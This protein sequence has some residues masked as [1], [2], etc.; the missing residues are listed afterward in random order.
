MFD[1]NLITT[2]KNLLAF[3][4]GIDSSA[5]F[6][7]LLEKNIQFD[8]A[9]VNYNIR[10]QSKQEVQYAK[11]LARKYNKE[12]YISIYD[13]DTFSE[14]DARDFRYKFFNNLIIKHNY[15]SLL[16]AHQLNDTFEWFLMQFSKGAGLVELIGLQKEELKD[17]Y[18]LYRPLL[19]I[20]KKE[21]KNY[22][23]ENNI[24]HFIDESNSNI[25]YKRNYFRKEFSDKFIS[26]YKNGVKRSISYLKND[27]NSLSSTYNI[28]EFENLYIAKFQIID[29]NIMIR[30]IDKT[31]KKFSIIIS[32]STR[33][34]ILKQKE[35]VISNKISVSIIN[36]MI[37]ISLYSNKIMDKKFKEKCR[38]LKIP[39]NIRSYLSEFNTDKFNE[40][41]NK[42]DNFNR[43]V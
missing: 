29:M 17:N 19:E 39:K 1:T 13:K 34:E 20:S 30:F 10:E 16:T 40:F 9:I 22:L 18:I 42:L 43:L 24:L 36:N 2:S 27:I 7:I 38:V 3:S 14:K 11:D 31:I 35:I 37:W 23:D 41:L 21:L 15:K 33:D 26:E 8:I 5:L 32:K 6:F 28:F 4:G 12:C 25:K